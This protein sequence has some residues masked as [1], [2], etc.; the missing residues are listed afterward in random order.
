[1]SKKNKQ[2]E[3]KRFPVH[4]E[5]KSTPI[6]WLPNIPNHWGI[7][8]NGRLFQQR[9]QVNAPELPIL[10]VSL[11]TGVTVRDFKNSHRKQKMTDHSLYKIA[12]QGDIAYNTMR[13]WQG[14][15]GV[16]PVDGLISPAYVVAQ[17]NSCSDS[18]FY[19]YLFRTKA[20]MNEVSKYSH[21]IVEDRNRLY[22]TEFKQMPSPQPPETEQT[23][24]AE[25]LD[26]KTTQINEFIITK[27]QLIKLLQEQKN[28]IINKAVTEGIVPNVRLKPSGVDWLGDIPEHWEV[29]K[30][31]Y[32]AQINPSKSKNIP[33]RNSRKLVT[34][35]PMESVSV[36]GEISNQYNQPIAELWNGY[37]Y[38]E[39]HDIVVAKITPC[40]ENGKAALLDNLT[41]KFGFGTTEFHVLRAKK[42][43]ISRFLFFIL[44]SETFM[45]T[46]EENMVGTA[47]Q[48][49]V[50]TAFVS[51]YPATYPDKE[52]QRDIINYIKN[53]TLIINL[54]ITKANQEIN[55]I[56]E[57]RESLIADAVTGKIDVRNWQGCQEEVT[58]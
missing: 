57:Y 56:K 20:Y 31:K 14:A 6:P 4:S 30:I 22:W 33:Q 10:E 5:Y 44:K 34:F 28:A 9:N 12:R 45:T 8:P 17:P 21:G 43:I 16:A 36:E 53:K 32:L 29:K 48:K 39:K 35:L 27:E 23:Y 7:L 54:A 50:P 11:N 47:G 15:V 51:N 38:F 37:T 55:L 19:A 49:R 41:S 46:G 42:Q 58:A 26:H 52:E 2:T 3:V 13:M 24:I 1:M 40:F 25:F 18:R